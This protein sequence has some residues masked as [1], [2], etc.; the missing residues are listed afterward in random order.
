MKNNKPYIAVLIPTFKHAI[1]LPA[2][3][4]SLLEQE[5]DNLF[6]HI[7]NDGSPDNTDEVMRKYI[8]LLSKRFTVQTT[9]HMFNQGGKGR[10]NVAFLSTVLP[11]EVD[12]IAL[13]DGD[14][15]IRDPKRFIKQLAILEKDPTI[16]AVH[17]DVTSLYENGA[18]IEDFWK[19]YRKT[20]TG[21]D[22]NIPTGYIVD[23]LKMCNFIFMS[24][25]LVRKELYKK[26]FDFKL[27][28]KLGIILGDYAGC[29]RLAHISK[30]DFI[31]ESLMF[32]RVLSNSA[33]H[34]NRDEIISDTVKLQAMAREGVLFT[35]L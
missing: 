7:S 30:I 1:Y 14:D 10:E 31:A 27:L 28:S 5:Y 21:N 13:I 8:S 17:S 34:A 4:E 26:A 11:D 3:F 24:S 2:L 15:Y 6:I 33:S 16:G 18:V 20:Q 19:K 9:S 12:Y 29:L 35:D 25:M 32:Y 22:P 23:H